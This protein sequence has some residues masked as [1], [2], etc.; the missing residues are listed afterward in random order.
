MIFSFSWSENE[1]SGRWNF[2]RHQRERSISNFRE[3]ERSSKIRSV[4][5]TA[6]NDAFNVHQLKPNRGRAFVVEVC[7]LHGN[8]ITCM[9]QNGQTVHRIAD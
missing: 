3:M 5:V 4:H 8:D 1:R 6:D 7:S 2:R 9:F